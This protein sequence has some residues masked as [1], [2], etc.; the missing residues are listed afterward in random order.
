MPVKVLV[1]TDGSE[2]S[3]V[4]AHRGCDLLAAVEQV[5]RLTVIADGDPGDDAGGIEGSVLSVEEQADVLAKELAEARDELART[6]AA[7]GGRVVERIETGEP[8]EAI[9]RTADRLGV[10]VVVVGSHGRTGLGRL[11]HGSVSEHVVR[12]A[13]CPVLVVHAADP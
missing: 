13:R 3:I 12:H 8:A 2:L 1:A 11:W 5:T 9:C 6:A 4:A 7:L 10:D